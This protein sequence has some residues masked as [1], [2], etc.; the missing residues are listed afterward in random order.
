MDEHSHTTTA[1]AALFVSLVKALDEKSPGIAPSFLKHLG[2]AWADLEESGLD[3]AANEI[4]A[5][6][7][8][9]LQCDVEFGE[10]AWIIY[11]RASDDAFL[12]LS[13]QVETATLKDALVFWAK[14][15][16]HERTIATIET[17]SGRRFDVARIKRLL[18]IY[19]TDPR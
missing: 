19:R 17:A 4:L 9:R 18:K 6:T 13:E 8:D 11:G 5:W 15:P 12:P 7:Q 1:M 2:E 14:L 16:E 3:P 10:P